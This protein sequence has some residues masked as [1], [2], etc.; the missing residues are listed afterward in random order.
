M[1]ER[2]GRAA[3]A[4]VTRPR[5]RYLIYCLLDLRPMRP[6]ERSFMRGMCH[7]FA[8]ERTQFKLEN[9]ALQARIEELSSELD[10][11]RKLEMLSG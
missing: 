6:I 5:G 7:R 2:A 1:T 8:C 3:A 4:L 9:R 10:A 11:R